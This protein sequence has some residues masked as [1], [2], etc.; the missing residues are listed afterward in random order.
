MAALLPVGLANDSRPFED[1]QI[2]RSL[3]LGFRL[4]DAV[5]RHAVQFG[6]LGLVDYDLPPVGAS[7]TD[8][9]NLRTVPPLYLAS[10]LEAAGLVPAAEMLAGLFASG[11]IQRDL[12]QATPLIIAFWRA[13]TQRFSSQERQAF[14]ARL[15][16][17]L[18]GATLGAPGGVNAEF[19]NL[20]IDFA[21]ALYK[22]NPN[23]ALESL[24]R[25]G[26]TPISEV[27]LQ[28]AAMNLTGNL[29]SRSGGMAGFAGRDLL[30]T[31]SQ[32]LE[33]VKNQ[34]IQSAFGLRTP[35]SVVDYV[36]RTYLRQTPDI[37]SHVTRGKSGMLL[38]TWLAEHVTALDD[39]GTFQI[40]SGDPLVGA[41]TAWL[42]ASL[43]LRQAEAA[44]APP[45]Q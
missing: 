25:F 37:T 26:V 3:G 8:Q 39:R 6:G 10:E 23:A 7:E 4:L 14:F 19:E 18:D 32:A 17:A 36:N 30:T 33:L 42:E 11:G 15:F 29:G 24:G 45:A 41:A 1:G 21:E 27:S 31:I 40:A 20:F 35:W 2:E 16:G 5:D 44:V 43:V 22:L 34:S 38:L 9:A 28:M 13:R 12:G